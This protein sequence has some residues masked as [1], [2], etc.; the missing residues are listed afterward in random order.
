MT[1]PLENAHY[2]DRATFERILDHSSDEIF[3]L[4][5]HQ[6]IVYVN[7]NCE[8]H[9]A[10]KPA[11][12]IGKLNE[13]FVRKGYWRPSVVGEVFNTKTPVTKLQITNTGTELVTTAIPVTNPQGDL[14]FVVSTARPFHRE[15]AFKVEK[16]VRTLSRSHRRPVNSGMISNSADMQHV[17]HVAQRAAQVDSTVLITGESGTGKGVLANYIHHASPRQKGTFLTINCAAI[18]EDLLESELFGYA[19]GAFTGASSR[20]KI[21]LIESANHGTIFLDEIGEISLKTQAKLL[22]LVQDHIFI[23]VGHHQHKAAD[24]RVIAATNQNL[25]Q[26]VEQGLFREDLFYRLNVMELVVPPLRTRPDD[27]VPLIH[28][29]LKQ[30]NQ[31]YN[32]QLKISEQTVHT[33][34]RYDWPGNIRQLQNV[35]ERSAILA[36]F[37]IEPNDLPEVILET[38]GASSDSTMEEPNTPEFP[39][40]GGMSLDDAL[41]TAERELVVASYE[42]H[43]STRKVARDLQ[44]SQSRASRLV[45]KY[46]SQDDL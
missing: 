40:N 20:G 36:D 34:R 30:F 1:N 21:G 28:L 19:A 10:L 5:K 32:K 24:V 33:M 18:P 44:I 4:D 39:T 12:V 9:Y 29:F 6:R 7:K 23:P 2:I 14:E 25:S 31:K 42:Q 37:V 3:V 15:E 35:M 43:R 17:L 8:R 26:M 27:F 16:N 13:D 45:R 46:F 38:S 41:S 11:E 22:Q